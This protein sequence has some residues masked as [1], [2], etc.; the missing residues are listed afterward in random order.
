MPFINKPDS[1]R[2]VIIFMISFISSFEV[3]NV[4]V[5][6]PNIFLWIAGSVAD[7][8]AVHPN[9]I[10]TL[11]ANGLSKFPIKDNP[12]FSND[13]KSLTKNTA[14]YPILNNWVFDNF[15]LA[16]ELFVKALQSFETSVLVNNNLCGKLFSSLESPIKLDEIFKVTSAL[17][18]V[19][20][21]NLLSCELGNFTFKGLYW[22]I[23]Y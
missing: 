15:I 19:P 8:A 14:N 21:F 9:G 17:F 11:L 1:S 2:G 22:V 6:D 12:V 4:V 7:A 5:P 23:L 3:I 18:F 16:E 10:K 20:D 13:P